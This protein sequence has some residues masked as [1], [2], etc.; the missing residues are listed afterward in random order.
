MLRQTPAPPVD[1]RVEVLGFVEDLRPLYARAAVVVAPLVV[2]SG[3]NIKVLEAMAC[4]KSIVSTAI[5]CA[6]L[7][8]HDGYDVLIGEDCREFARTVCGLL[9]DESLRSQVGGN[10]RRTAEERFGWD[11]I[12]SRAF[13]SYLTVLGRGE[14]IAAT[15]GRHSR[16]PAHGRF[17]E[18]ERQC[19]R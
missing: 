13:Q 18:L 15:T 16:R 5:G 1:E 8:L 4:G 2:S 12:G 14:R 10:A 19:S 11:A 17:R 6:G 3:T 7:G 9:S